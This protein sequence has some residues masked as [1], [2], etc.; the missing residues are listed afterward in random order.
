MFSSRNKALEQTKAYKYKALKTFFFIFQFCGNNPRALYLTYCMVAVLTVLLS[1]LVCNS[2]PGGNFRTFLLSLHIK[3]LLE[4]QVTIFVA[5]R[6]GGLAGP[7]RY[8]SASAKRE[9][10]KNPPVVTPLFM[11]FRPL[12]MIDVH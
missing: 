5:C 8:T 4:G 1:V 12:E 11:L 3:A 6:T 2:N 9:A 7:A 10:K